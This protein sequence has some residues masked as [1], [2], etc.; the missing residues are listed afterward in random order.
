MRQW[1]RNR[2]QDGGPHGRGHGGNDGSPGR[3]LGQDG[4]VWLIPPRKNPAGRHLPAGA[5][6]SSVLTAR[7]NQATAASSAD[8]ATG[9]SR[10]PDGNSSEKDWRYVQL[11]RP[12]WNGSR[13]RLQLPASLQSAGGQV[14]PAREAERESLD[15]FTGLQWV[16]RP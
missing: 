10:E 13:T 11:L 7:S 9:K 16:A 6:W 4:C 3:T 15:L 2:K 5:R 1:M 14:G 12:W 8:S